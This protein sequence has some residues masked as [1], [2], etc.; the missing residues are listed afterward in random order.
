[1]Q[2][3]GSEV[4]QP[5]GAGS[6]PK[7]RVLTAITSI[8]PPITVISSVLVFFGWIKADAQAKYMGL[9]VSLFGYTTQDYVLFSLS[10]LSIALVCLF[11]VG[12][13]CMALDRWLK[14]R[15]KNPD[16]RPTMR[17]VARLAAI[18]GILVAGTALLLAALQ[19]GRST[20]YAPYV[21]AAGVLFTVWAARVYRLA[22]DGEPEA[23]SFEQRIGEGALLFGLVTLLLFWAAADHAQD[24]GRRM[25]MDI[26]QHV[27]ALPRAEIYSTRPLAID[28]PVI[29]ETK[30]GTDTAPVYRYD[31]LRL[32]E[33][34]GGNLFFLHDGWTAQTGSVVVLPND[35]SVR[36]EYGR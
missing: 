33:V 5:A 12:V 9:N 17:R 7:H 24:V 27:D 13:C 23:R 15:M 36:I 34:S 30:L 3:R 20:L 1:M 6:A 8:G 10:N 11:I 29:T 16:S 2:V 21:I 14:R 32:L 19:P 22:Q 28:S 26:E 31:G 35:N 18:L 4:T 25:A